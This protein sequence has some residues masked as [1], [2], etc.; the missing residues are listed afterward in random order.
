M[1]ASELRTCQAKDC[2]KDAFVQ[3]LGRFTDPPGF[4]FWWCED[5]AEA[6]INPLSP[7]PMCGHL[8]DT[9]QHA[10]GCERGRAE[11]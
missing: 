6:A 5:H 8:K 3:D 9:P 4:E 11:G 1:R 7:C 2:D 10:L